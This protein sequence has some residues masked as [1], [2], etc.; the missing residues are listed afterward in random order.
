M[1]GFTLHIIKTDKSAFNFV[2]FFFVQFWDAAKQVGTLLLFNETHMIA[3]VLLSYNVPYI[4]NHVYILILR[5][6]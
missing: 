4:T 1:G 2:Q 5:I 6:I 3:E